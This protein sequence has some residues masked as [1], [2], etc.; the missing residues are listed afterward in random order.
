MS[1]A[2]T[3]P[4]SVD[5]FGWCTWDAFYSS[6]EPRG[7][8]EGLQTLCDA[9]VPPRTLILDD[10]WQQVT[11]SKP[12]HKPPSDAPAAKGAGGG[13]GEGLSA[14]TASPAAAPLAALRAAA[15]A[16]VA[17]VGGRLLAAISAVFERFYERLTLRSAWLRRESTKPTSGAALRARCLWL[18]DA[19]FES[20]P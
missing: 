18:C 12:L 2:K 5:W 1:T 8:Y 10:G 3:L 11:P 6:V 14:V 15:T 16:I 13:G 17:W 19:A 9:G 4:P 7:V 20:C